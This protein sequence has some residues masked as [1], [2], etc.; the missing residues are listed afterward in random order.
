MRDE[1]LREASNIAWNKQRTGGKWVREDRGV[2]NVASQFVVNGAAPKEATPSGRESEELLKGKIRETVNELMKA[3]SER[4]V[5]PP[6]M[7]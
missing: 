2:W 4:S 5:P 6:P 3:A 7:Q 1:K